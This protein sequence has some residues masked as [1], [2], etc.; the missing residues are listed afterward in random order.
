[1]AIKV[2]TEPTITISGKTDCTALYEL[3]EHAV[4]SGTFPSME[5]E[6]LARDCMASLKQPLGI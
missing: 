3:L 6:Q 4:N 2:A 5:A 1:M